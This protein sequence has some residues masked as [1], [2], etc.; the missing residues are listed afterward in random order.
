ME[1]EGEGE[2]ARK[3]RQVELMKV[4]GG[5]SVKAPGENFLVRSIDSREARRKERPWK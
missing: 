3:L 5:C 2:N 4:Y 1:H